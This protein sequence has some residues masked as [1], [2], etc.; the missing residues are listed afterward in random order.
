MSADIYHRYGKERRCGIYT[1]EFRSNIKNCEI[2]IC[3]PE[4][5]QMLLFLPENQQ[6]ASE[7][8]YVIFDEIHCI[9]EQHLETTASPMTYTQ[10]CFPFRALSPP[11]SPTL[12]FLKVGLGLFLHQPCG[13]DTSLSFYQHLRQFLP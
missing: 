1:S 5:F 2:M 10:V 4:I 8:L 6:W 9:A 7:L 13:L 3:T 12:L 11:D